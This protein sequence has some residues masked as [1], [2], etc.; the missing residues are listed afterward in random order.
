MVTHLCGDHTQLCLTWLLSVS[1][2][3]FTLPFHLFFFSSF[4]LLY[5][6]S[7]TLIEVPEREGDMRCFRNLPV[8]ALIYDSATCPP[9]CTALRK[10]QGEGTH[11]IKKMGYGCYSSTVSTKI[12]FTRNKYLKRRQDGQQ[13]KRTR[14]I[15]NQE[16]M[17]STIILFG[18]M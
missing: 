4:L 16:L 14:E 9:T 7:P 15:A 6:S 18:L 3:A 10:E 17:H 12:V 5:P 13:R 2:L 11:Q 1:A 8:K